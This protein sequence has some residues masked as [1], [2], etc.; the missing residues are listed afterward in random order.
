MKLKLD[1]DA[2]TFGDMEDFESAAGTPLGEVMKHFADAAGDEANILTS[3]RPKEIIALIWILARH[4][5]ESF[6]IEQARKIPIADLEFE[7]TP[8]DPT[9]GSG[10]PS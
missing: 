1:L 6:T 9:E 2:L 5:D 3:F 8:P 10:T 7:E 4:D